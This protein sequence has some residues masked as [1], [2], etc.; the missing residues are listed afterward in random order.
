MT[1]PSE[2]PTGPG[3]LRVLT[4]LLSLAAI[5]GGVA[6]G[7]AAVMAAW[8]TFA[9]C[10]M[11]VLALAGCAVCSWLAASDAARAKTAARAALANA[12]MLRDQ[13]DY[14]RAVL[15]Q[16]AGLVLILHGWLPMAAGLPEWELLLGM[17][18]RQAGRLDSITN[19][20]VPRGS[21]TESNPR[22]H[23]PS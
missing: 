17:A 21:V 4:G 5:G 14:E 2:P 9:G 11:T 23:S 22:R 6:A 16:M 13:V 7:A 12:T 19:G 3:F 18:R 10:V 8:I 15:M 1:G 20:W